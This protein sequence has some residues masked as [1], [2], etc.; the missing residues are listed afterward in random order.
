MGHAG[1]EVLLELLLELIHPGLRRPELVLVLGEG[2]L[3]DAEGGA[4]PALLEPGV[5]AVERHGR[6]GVRHPLRPAARRGRLRLAHRDVL[7][8]DEDTNGKHAPVD[9]HKGIVGVDGRVELAVRVLVPVE[10]LLPG[11]GDLVD[12]VHDGRPGGAE[13]LQDLEGHVLQGALLEP[14]RLEPQLFLDLRVVLVDRVPDLGRGGVPVEGPERGRTPRPLVRLLV[15]GALVGLL[16]DELLQLRGRELVLRREAGLD[17]PHAAGAPLRR[18]LVRVLQEPAPEDV[19]GEGDAPAPQ[20]RLPQPDDLDLAPLHVPD[21]VLRLGH[22]PGVLQGQLP[23]RQHRAGEQVS[24]PDARRG[25]LRLLPHHQLAAEQAVDVLHEAVELVRGVLH[26]LQHGLRVLCG[27]LLQQPGGVLLALQR[28]LVGHAPLAR[29]GA[30]PVPG[31]QE[32]DPVDV[33]AARTRGSQ[34]PRPGVRSASVPRRTPPLPAPPGATSP[35]GLLRRST[36]HQLRWLGIG[37]FQP[38]AVDARVGLEGLAGLPHHVAPVRA[39]GARRRPP[40]GLRL[41]GLPPRR[42]ATFQPKTRQGARECSRVLFGAGEGGRGD[43]SRAC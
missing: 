24:V 43:L 11:L 26:Q 3:G 19:L 41:P 32:R 5:A 17:D 16:D 10:V 35:A 1:R 38:V 39:A 25:Q 36:G 15:R 2:A 31:A 22:P 13:R 34:I 23:G 8:R 42:A 37:G 27:E 33:L 28:L 9:P 4:D 29:E 14:G 40:R 6:R 21:L 20:L 18:V 30:A 12:Q 7:A